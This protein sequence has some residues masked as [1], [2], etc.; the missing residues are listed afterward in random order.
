MGE[1]RVIKRLVVGGLLGSCVGLALLVAIGT[2]TGYASGFRAWGGA[3][4]GTLEAAFAGALLVLIG[5]GLPAAGIGLAVGVAIA[6][7]TRP[8]T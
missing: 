4:A 8:R 5:G 6:Y 2:I 7:W 1:R 3:S